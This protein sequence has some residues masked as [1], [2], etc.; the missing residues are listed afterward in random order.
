M[1]TALLKRLRKKFTKRYV[2]VFVIIRR[3]WDRPVKR[4]YKIIY[5]KSGEVMSTS[6]NRKKIEDS[7][8]EIINID[9]KGY[10]QRH[11]AKTKIV[12]IYPW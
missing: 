10:L 9:I 3:G 12:N 8:R 4:H 2:V 11:G 1:K 6:Q 7:L 5:K